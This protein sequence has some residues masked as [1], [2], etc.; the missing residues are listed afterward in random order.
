MGNEMFHRF[1]FSCYLNLIR[2]YLNH[3]YKVV[4]SLKTFTPRISYHK[5]ELSREF[6]HERMDF[7]IHAVNSGS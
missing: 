5:G 3:L 1:Y 4:I 6:N 7:S 2:K